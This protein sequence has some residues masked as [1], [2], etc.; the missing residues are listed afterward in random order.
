MKVENFVLFI[1]KEM[2]NHNKLNHSDG[3]RDF[4]HSFMW[5][6]NGIIFSEYKPDLVINLRVA[7]DIINDRKTISES[8]MRPFFIDITDLL[9]IDTPA[10]NYMASSEAC[11]FLS[12]GAVYT[13]NKLLAFL[14]NAWILLDKPLIP[15]KV[16][17]NK[18]AGLKW[19]EPFK[20]QN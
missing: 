4:Y 8:I 14:G 6:S 7:K 19:L 2:I 9:S 3:R 11:E 10:R 15:S 1:N 5:I 20:Y 13:N 18:E 16:F 12:A 17:T